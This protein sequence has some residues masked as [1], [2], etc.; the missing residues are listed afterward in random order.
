MKT[1]LLLSVFALLLNVS[2]Y[3]QFQ[4]N[5]GAAGEN[6]HD[7]NQE[8]MN[9]G[10][11]DIMVA[12]NLFDASMTNQTFTLKRIDQT[13]TVLWAQKYD[14]PSFP[15][16]RV[17][18]IVPYL[19]IIV[20]TGS[21]D[22]GGTKRTFI[23]RI[24]A[25]TGSVINVKYYDIVSP[26]FNSRGLQIEYTDSDANGDA[27]PDP[28]FIVGGFFSSCYNLDTNCSLNIGFVL[29]V[30]NNL[31]LIWASELDTSVP[32]TADYDFI[33]GITETNDGFFLTGSATGLNAANNTQQGVL[34]HKIDFT[35]SPVWD[36]SYIFGNSRDV[37]VD[38]YFDVTSQK[39]YMLA[40]YSV[41]HY[42]GVT[43]LDN[44]TGTIDMTSSW[45]ATSGDVDRYGFTL[46]ESATSSNNLVVT[47]Y[48]RQENFVDAAGVAQTGESNIFV[49]EFEKSSG[50]AVGVN[51]QFLLPHTEPAGDEFNF[52]N[53]QMPLIYY[54]DISFLYSEIPGAVGNY[55]HVGYRTQAAGSFTEAELFKTGTDKRNICDNLVLNITPSSINIFPIQVMSGST[56][57]SETPMSFTVNGFNYTEN[58]CSDI[59]GTND[60]E[61]ETGFIYPNPVQNELQTTVKNAQD[62]QVLDA[63]GRVVRNG[64]FAQESVVNTSELPN[65]LYF[66]TISN[67]LRQ[68]Q[69]FKFLKK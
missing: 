37:S 27:T 2:V 45:Y 65:G 42:F 5:V 25:T 24:L 32:A 39:I 64:N 35:G 53:G 29:R 41:S 26:N 47:G 56:P 14:N 43:V 54:P 6:Y 11:N 13:G 31:D 28:G 60:F 50:N 67:E 22:V 21:I 23:A 57:A 66:I 18:D 58:S 46:M 48:D 17:F 10:S 69:T 3:A 7:L 20:A 34:A 36:R 55:Y 62:Y 44:T 63:T 68:V 59:L 12:A 33:N 4:K 9:D 1:T 51:Y 15:N 52:W 49:Y 30:N 19:D 40:N 8:P 16:A 61:K 38:A